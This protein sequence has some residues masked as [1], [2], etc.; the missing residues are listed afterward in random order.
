MGMQ[1]KQSRVRTHGENAYGLFTLVVSRVERLSPSYIRV[2]LTGPALQYAA[3]PI[4]LGGLSNGL[5]RDDRAFSHSADDGE[6]YIGVLDGY[7]KLLIPPAAQ[8]D[9]HG[10]ISAL[11][12]TLFT[13]ILTTHGGKIGLPSLNL[14]AAGCALTRYVLPVCAFLYWK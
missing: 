13:L 3:R 6:S 7:I 8:R 5:G 12:K 1:N 4:A 11:Q 14:N 10:R 2:S 9:E